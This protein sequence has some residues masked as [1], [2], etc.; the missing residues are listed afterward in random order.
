MTIA[1]HLLALIRGQA[2]TPRRAREEPRL[3][4]HLYIIPERR[5]EPCPVPVK[6]QR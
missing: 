1:K 4:E 2:E 5:P 3:P 6:L